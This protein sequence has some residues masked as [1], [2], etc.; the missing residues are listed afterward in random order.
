[1]QGDK[2]LLL[3]L[4]KRLNFTLED[5]D[6]VAHAYTH[7]RDFLITDDPSIDWGPCSAILGSSVPANATCSSTASGTTNSAKNET[8]KTETAKN[9][10]VKTETAKNETVKTETA[11]TETAKTETAK[12]ETETAKTETAK[13]ET[14]KTE[15]AHVTSNTTPNENETST[16]PTANKAQ[17]TTNKTT[18]STTTIDEI[19]TNEITNGN[20]TNSSNDSA[21]PKF[22]AR[23]IAIN[24]PQ[25]FQYERVKELELWAI[26]LITRLYITM[27]PSFVNSLCI[28]LRNSLIK[29]LHNFFIIIKHAYR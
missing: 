17:T 16:D 28:P 21:C 6:V 8:A 27:F 14:A 5:L 11:K 23:A 7:F 24:F 3:A 19:A 26:K 1:L 18:T 25:Y 12:T 2:I 29:S 9:E 10:T 4:E 15:T 13:T 20:T 22:Y